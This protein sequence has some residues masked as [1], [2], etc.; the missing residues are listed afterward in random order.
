[1][2]LFHRRGKDR[3]KFFRDG[4]DAEAHADHVRESP[5]RPERVALAD[6]FNLV[7]CVG[8][9]AV[10]NAKRLAAI[11]K[12]SVANVRVIDAVATPKQPSHFGN[13]P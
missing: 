13:H 2:S 11:L 10:E 9:Q 8:T 3:I 1:V 12:E 6:I 7:A 5:D 4:Q